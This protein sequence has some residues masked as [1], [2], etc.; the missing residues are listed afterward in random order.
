MMAG[1]RQQPQQQRQQQ[2]QNMDYGGGFE[3]PQF[4]EAEENMD[5]VQWDDFEVMAC[6]TP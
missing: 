4:E 6:I 3:D 5:D 1:Q 2:E